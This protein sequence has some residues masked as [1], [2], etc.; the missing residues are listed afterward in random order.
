MSQNVTEGEEIHSDRAA[1][2]S[3]GHI[4]PENRRKARTVPRKGNKGKGK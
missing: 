4:T 2:V 3:R 1:E